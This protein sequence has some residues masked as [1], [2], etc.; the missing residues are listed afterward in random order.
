MSVVVRGCGVLLPL[1]L[2]GAATAAEPAV[3]VVGTEL[4]A[5]PDSHE[6]Q[7]ARVSLRNAGGP[8]RGL[9]VACTF[10]AEDGR[11]LE[12][13]EAAAPEIAEGA[14]A[15]AEVIYYGWPRASRAACRL[16]DGR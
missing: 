12:V 10:Q 9:V 2:A 8:A 6:P 3:R 14:T 1:L 5:P 11:T 13:A 4:R 16:A 7:R 15:T